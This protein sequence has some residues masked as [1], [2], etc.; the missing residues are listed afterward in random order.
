MFS[1]KSSRLATRGWPILGV[2]KGRGDCTDIRPVF[3]ARPGFKLV[4]HDL[5]Q[6]EVRILT[7][8]SKCKGLIAA[9]AADRDVYQEAAD[10]TGLSRK[11]CKAMVLARF[12]GASLGRLKDATGLTF[13]Q[14]TKAVNDLDKV[15]PEIAKFSKAIVKHVE[16]VKFIETF[17]G[18]RFQFDGEHSP[19]KDAANRLAQSTVSQ[20]IQKAMVDLDDKMPWAPL[21]A[22]IHDE[23]INEVPEDRTEEFRLRAEPIITHQP[24]SSVP[25]VTD[26]RTGLSWGDL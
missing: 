23:I 6:A 24:W 22:Q 19:Y 10:S 25:F 2:T 21:W 5:G 7:H 16:K 1:V 15:Y 13:Q 12:Y 14:T 26:A 18:R 9:F 11:V 4:A 8:Y 20:M 17:S 3:V